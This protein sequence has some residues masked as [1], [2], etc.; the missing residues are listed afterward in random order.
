MGAGEASPVVAAP[1]SYSGARWRG[2]TG[3]AEVSCAQCWSLMA[4]PDFAKL[5]RESKYNLS[6]EDEDEVDVHHHHSL[7]GKDDFDEEVPL[8]DDSDEEGQTTLSKKRIPLQS[9]GLPSETD[10]SEKTSGHK[11]EKEVM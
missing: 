11:N 9:S 1:H 8:G 5:K 7:S 4:S 10:L 2:R 3:G 6:D